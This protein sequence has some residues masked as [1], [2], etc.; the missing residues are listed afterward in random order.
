[1]QDYAITPGPLPNSDQVVCTLFEGHYHFGVGAL[2][3]SLV[4]GGFKGL[5]WAGYRGNLPPWTN[6]LSEVGDQLFQLPNGAQLKFEKL[7]TGVHFTNYKPD[8]MLNLIRRRIATKLI[9]YFDPDITVQ[10]SWSF[11]RKWAE[12]GVSICSEIINGYMPERHPVRCMWEDVARNAGWGP[13]VTAQTR[14][15][16]AGFVGLDTAYASFLERWKRAIEIA[17][18]TGVSLNDFMPGTRE[19]A[20]Y[21][22]DQDS[23]NLTTMYATEPI[24]AIGPEGMGF[25]HGGFTMFHS[26]GSPK[27][28]NKK[29]FLSSLRGIPPG[30]GDKHFLTSANA[31]IRL[32]SRGELRLKRLDATAGALIG[33]FYSR[34]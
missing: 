3:N 25:I 22:I 32:Y 17:T 2:L 26:V 7:D 16:N 21:V 15:F 29:H 19:D 18:Q 24:S 8:L 20:Y 27:P 31:P 10:C 23:L 28:W 12:R 11:L 5:M 9:L 1:M 33:R 30:R 4:T 34:R 14:Y 13:P 6:Q